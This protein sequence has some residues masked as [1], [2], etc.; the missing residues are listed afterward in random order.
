MFRIIQKF[1]VLASIVACSSTAFSATHSLKLL[2]SGKDSLAAHLQAIRGARST[3]D[4]MSYELYPCDASSIAILNALAERAD[5]G[6]RVR[7]VLD[8]FFLNS[9]TEQLLSGFFSAHN[10]TLRLYN[11]RGAI[12]FKNPR[13]HIKLFI[14]GAATSKRVY[15]SDSRNLGD[16]YFG[17][18]AKVNLTGRDLMIQGPSIKQAAAGF[19]RIYNYVGLVHGAKSSPK[20]TSLA[21]ACIAG[22]GGRGTTYTN[23]LENYFAENSAK[24]LNSIPTY[25]C[26]NVQYY[27]DDPKF[28]RDRLG[29]FDDG[30]PRNGPY[31]NDLRLSYK[32][33]SRTTLDFIRG[34]QGSL[35]I[36]NQFYIP[37]FQL[38][39]ELKNA[40]K[41]GRDVKILVITN[42]SA[43]EMFGSGILTHQMQKAVR[44]SQGQPV[45]ILPISSLGSIRGNGNETSASGTRWY[46]QSKTAVRDHRDVMV[47]SFSFDSRSLQINLESTAV[48]RN[49]P[50][51]ARALEKEYLKLTQIYD[52]DQTSC[53]ACT[54]EQPAQGLF[55][56]CF[57]A[58]ASSVR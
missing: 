2:N 56:A 31:L 50:A 52:H 9:R 35:N 39:Q 5:N 18:D 53:A 45:N 49:C 32:H 26:S 28:L 19:E 30:G 41:P 11:G 1:I 46:I 57:G 54:K 42:G 7:V 33:T 48:V 20:V 55:S 51:L 12:I 27:S 4:I 23:N 16:E 17:F 8:A 21:A 6:V 58:L 10:M 13:N 24:I 38:R 22:D 14:I 40:T 44:K 43:M 36:E 29:G 37:M 25:Q 3:I 15:F 34:A 47:G